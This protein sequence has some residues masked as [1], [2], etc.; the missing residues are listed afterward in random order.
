MRVFIRAQ[1]QGQAQDWDCALELAGFAARIDEEW[2]EPLVFQSFIERDRRN[3]GAVATLSAEALKRDPEHPV[4]QW[5]AGLAATALGDWAQARAAWR[6]YGLE[7]EAGDQPID[8]DFGLCPLRL[9]SDHGYEEVVWARRICPV[10]AAIVSVPYPQSGYR[11][12]DLVL[13]DGVPDGLVE[14]EDE[15]MPVFN[16]LGTLQPARLG[17]YE[18]AVDELDSAVYAALIDFAKSR[19][20]VIETWP[21]SVTAMVDGVQTRLG[22]AAPNLT[23]VKRL[24]ADFAAQHAEFRFDS[25]RQLLRPRRASA[26][27]S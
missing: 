25:P 5:N 2:A 4:A 10:R 12:G 15:A 24:F 27:R 8:G 20:L 23:V 17:T 11:C 1:R 3:F 13:H 7:V 19:D 22:I 26:V 16:V 18:C 6:R 14:R 21:T 9:R